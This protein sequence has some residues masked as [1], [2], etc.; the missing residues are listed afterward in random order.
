MS[1]GKAHRGSNFEVSV[2]IGHDL[3]LVGIVRLALVA[4]NVV[5]PVASFLSIH[6]IVGRVEGSVMLE[7]K[8]FHQLLSNGHE[9]KNAFLIYN[10]PRRNLG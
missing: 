2:N 5:E 4:V 8:Y 3:V 7:F 9:E 10:R 6:C 1:S